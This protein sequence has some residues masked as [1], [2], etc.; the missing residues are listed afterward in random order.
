LLKRFLL[1][2]Q[3]R[4]RYNIDQLIWPEKGEAKWVKKYCYTKVRANIIAKEMLEECPKSHV[5]I[6]ETSV[7][8]WRVELP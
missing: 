7:M 8:K 2:H 6:S 4:V 1:W 5:W 3:S